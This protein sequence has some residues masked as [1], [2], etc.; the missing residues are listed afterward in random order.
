MS[1]QSRAHIALAGDPGSVSSTH[2]AAYRHLQCQFE[3][4][5]CPFLTSLDTQHAHGVHTYV[6]AKHISIQFFKLKKK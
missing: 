1:H 4:I 5:Q 6:L 2:L 3:G